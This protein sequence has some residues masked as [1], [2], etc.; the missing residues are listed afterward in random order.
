MIKIERWRKRDNKN[1]KT[2]FIPGPMCLMGLLELLVCMMTDYC[3]FN[4]K[5]RFKNYREVTDL[6]Y[7]VLSI[8]IY[9]YIKIHTY[10]YICT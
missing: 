3:Q 10:V 6:V 1:K 8:L 4:L 2:T 5:L 7:Y 9:I